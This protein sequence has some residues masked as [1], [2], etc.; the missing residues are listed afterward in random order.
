MRDIRRIFLGFLILIFFTV[1]YIRMPVI[2]NYINFAKREYFGQQEYEIIHVSQSLTRAESRTVE[3][4]AESVVRIL[5]KMS[6]GIVSLS[7]TMVSYDGQFFVLTAAHG[8]S[9]NCGDMLI[10]TG[11]EHF[12]FCESVVILDRELDY[13]ILKVKEQG[14]AISV[15]LSRVLPS[16]RQRQNIFSLQNQLFYTGFPNSNGP[17]T[18]SGTIIGFAPNDYI[19]MHSYAWSGSSG[20]GVFTHDGKLMGIVIALDIGATRFGIDVLEDMVIVLPVYKM[21]WDRILGG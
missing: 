4:S 19:F 1:V 21:D 10:W 15:N 3:M 16:E 18:I 14:E 9:E 13:A 20:S 2:K 5:T 11:S 7:G 6:G 8:V 17:V 12:Q